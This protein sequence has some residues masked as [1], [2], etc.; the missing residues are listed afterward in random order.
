MI[1]L[2]AC[3]AGTYLIGRELHH[4]N[5]IEWLELNELKP[6]RSAKDE[7]DLEMTYGTKFF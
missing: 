3:L 6:V 7:G 1:S 5:R 4:G 2:A